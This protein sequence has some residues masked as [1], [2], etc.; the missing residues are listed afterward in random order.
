MID[1][2]GA[3]RTEEARGKNSKLNDMLEKRS[4]VFSQTLGHMSIKAHLRLK[5]GARPELLKKG[6][7]WVWTSECEKAVKQNKQML[8]SNLV[9]MRYDPKLPIKVMTDASDVGVGATL[10]QVCPGD[11]ERPVAYA[12]RVLT[13]AERKYRSVEKEAVI[14]NPD[15]EMPTLG[16]ARMQRY[17]FKLAAYSYDVELRR[18][19]DMRLADT[20]SRLLMSGIIDK[21][22][23][24]LDGMYGAWVG[25]G[26]GRVSKKLH[27]V[28]SYGEASGPT[29]VCGAPLGTHPFTLAESARRLCGNNKRN[30]A[31]RSGEQFLQMDRS[32][33]NEVNNSREDYT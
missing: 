26:V 33:P 31:T 17:A 12:S 28:Y 9:L 3:A 18:S 15:R 32:N 23:H 4:E 16:A 30:N 13:P 14:L 2:I 29:T 25:Q 19:E 5:E 8:S 21:G 20:L 7:K 27:Q 24:W 11:V 22:A 10:I 6:A 1:R